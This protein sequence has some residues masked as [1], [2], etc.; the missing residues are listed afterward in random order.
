MDDEEKEMASLQGRFLEAMNARQNNDVDAAAE[1]LRGIIKVEPRL[2]EPHM[3]LA[4]ILICVGQLDE[5]LTHAEEAVNALEMGGQWTDDLPENTMK[6]LAYGVL[7]EVYRL[8]ADS[9]EV[10]FGEPEKWEDLVKRS[11]NAFQKAAALDENN[12]H[13]YHWGYAEHWKSQPERSIP[14]DESIELNP[15]LFPMI[16]EVE[17]PKA[18][19]STGQ[20]NE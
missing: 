20:E 3:E 11:K 10:V 7:G 15:G 6:S 14:A 8:Q 1:L 17:L 19:S 4:H 13:A 2:P 12:A 9:D 18:S 16:D 5:A